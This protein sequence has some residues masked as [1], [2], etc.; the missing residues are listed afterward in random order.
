MMRFCRGTSAGDRASLDLG[1]LGFPSGLE[2]DRV[3][4]MNFYL[5]FRF[6]SSA[7][8]CS[9]GD[10]DRGRVFYHVRFDD[11]F[12]GSIPQDEGRNE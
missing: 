6:Q 11:E 1:K 8:P 9:G 7:F 4:R 12:L 5:G 10:A 2:R 3:G